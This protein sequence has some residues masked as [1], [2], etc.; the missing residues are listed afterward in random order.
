MDE[1][2]PQF[3]YDIWHLTNWRN[4]RVLHGCAKKTAQLTRDLTIWRRTWAV[5]WTQVDLE[6]RFRKC[7]QATALDEEVLSTM[8]INIHRWHNSPRTALDHDDFGPALFLP[9]GFIDWIEL[10]QPTLCICKQMTWP[11]Q[12]RSSSPPACQ[13]CSKGACSPRLGQSSC[14]SGG[15]SSWHHCGLSW[16]MIPGWQNDIQVFLL[17]VRPMGPRNPVSGWS[18][19]WSSVTL[20]PPSCLNDDE[21]ET[22]K[23]TIS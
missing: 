12:S 22:R 6:S 3:L 1:S 11:P 17:H 21:S 23:Q 13:S 19:T 5:T 2:V 7:Y 14:K 18:A 15:A 16:E 9:D 10:K 8:W 20:R 4:F